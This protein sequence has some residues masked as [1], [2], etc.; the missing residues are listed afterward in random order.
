MIFGFLLLEEKGGRDFFQK[1]SRER[2]TFSGKLRR[3]I[4]IFLV[5]SLGGIS[6]KALGK[7]KN[8]LNTFVSRS[9]RISVL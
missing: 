6:R 4:S 8:T 5:V 2:F 1:I 9:V 3:N 7:S